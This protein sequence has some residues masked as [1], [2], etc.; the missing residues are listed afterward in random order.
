[1]R[2][3]HAFIIGIVCG[4]IGPLIGLFLYGTLIANQLEIGNFSEFVQYAKTTGTEAK[5]LS[6]SMLFNLIL[7]FIFINI[8]AWFDASRGVIL[9]SLIWAGPILYYIFF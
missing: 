5:V 3:I 6:F 1:M 2:R 4:L 7:F 8:P 9:A